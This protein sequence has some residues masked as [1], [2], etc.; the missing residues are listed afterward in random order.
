MKLKITILMFALAIFGS[1]EAEARTQAACA[2]KGSRTVATDTGARVFRVSKEKRDPAYG[3]R[4][5]LYFFYGC[6]YRTDRK[7][8]LGADECLS[9]FG[10]LGHM[11]L[12]G[13][14]VAY[15]TSVC[16]PD[17]DTR[18]AVSV[19]DLRT[20]R[21]RVFPEFLSPPPPSVPCLPTECPALP[22]APDT[23]VTALTLTTNGS[24]AWITRKVGV[25]RPHSP[26]R[27]EPYVLYEVRKA[28]KSGADIVLDSGADVDP[29][30]LRLSTD[31]TIVYWTKRGVETSAPLQ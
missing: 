15:A 26:T 28:D 20:G 23:Q 14:Y 10:K 4:V 24:V 16:S 29:A 17:R 21:K 25:Y 7:Y 13:R 27:L 5:V 2:V 12:A 3:R 30:S 18:T 9:S 22:S 19:T 6:L 8:Y 31:G 1:A 11:R